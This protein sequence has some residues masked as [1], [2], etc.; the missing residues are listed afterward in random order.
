MYIFRSYRLVADKQLVLSNL[1]RTHLPLTPHVT[2]PPVILCGGLAFLF[3][4]MR[5]SNPKLFSKALSICLKLQHYEGIEAKLHL[6]PQFFHRLILSEEN[7][8]RQVF[9]LKKLLNDI[10]F[11]CGFSSIIHSMYSRHYSTGFFTE[12]L[13]QTSIY[14][15][16][17]YSL[18]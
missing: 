8:N 6:Y 15:I 3:L 17:M 4:D 7:F 14:N 12:G 13:V 10:T 5:F 18:C 2:H 16:Q 9:K 1:E 11:S